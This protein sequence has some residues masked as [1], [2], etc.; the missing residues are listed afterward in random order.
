MNEPAPSDTRLRDA[1]VVL[2]LALVMLATRIHHFGALPD[3][4]WVVFFAGGFYVHR[5]VR[6]AFPLLLIL[7]VAIDYAIITGGGQNFWSHYCVS[8]AYWFLQVGY[9]AMWGGGLWLA[10]HYARPG[11]RELGLL[12]LS[13]F[14]ATSACY[15]ISN[16]SFYWLSPNVALRS[17]DGWMANLGHWY[18]PYLRT[19]AMYAGIGALLHVGT[20]FAAHALSEAAASH[21]A[22]RS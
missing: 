14:A 16:G 4:S 6:W 7:G 20:V 11:L 17:F 22:A 8:P 5:R 18:L 10:R 2:I 9:A 12:A 15:L 1:G 13:L 3:A 21:D 19:A